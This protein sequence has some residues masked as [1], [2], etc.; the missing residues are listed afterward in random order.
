MYSEFAYSRTMQV[1]LAVMTFIFTFVFIYLI[2]ILI[3]HIFDE[4]A[5]RKQKAVFAFLVGGVLNTIWAYAV[6]FIGGMRSFTPIVYAL[7]VNPNPIFAL[8]YYII[9]VK[10]LKIPPIRS[11]KMMGHVYLYY[12][13]VQIFNRI[14]NTLFFVQATDRYNYMLDAAC[15]FTLLC[16]VWIIYL[17]TKYLIRRYN[18]TINLNLFIDFKKELVLYILKTTFIYLMIVGLPLYISNQIVANLIIFFIFILI[19][20][21]TNLWELYQ[22]V[23]NEVGY[24]DE[25]IHVLSRDNANSHEEVSYLQ[26]RMKENPSLISILIGKCDYAKKMNVKL[27]M[28]LLSRTD[29]FYINNIDICRI[30]DCLLE[31]AIEAAAVSE[32]KSVSFT[33]VSKSCGEKLIII[34]NSTTLPVETNK[35]IFRGITTIYERQGKGIST[36]RKIVSKHGN[37]TFK[38]TYHNNDV[39]TY[40]EVTMQP[41]ETSEIAKINWG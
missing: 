23:K 32:R 7:V 11:I 27:S 3:L 8:L 28:K 14:L 21:L 9:G 13:I 18:Y 29:N 38:T 34:N 10:V 12:V 35:I 22:S 19:F 31:N 33:V 20:L 6:Y 25:Y 40:L 15:Q 30:V 2:A 4:K 1:I 16:V 36:V 37:C 39:S 41:K 26:K 17:A 24:K 5:G